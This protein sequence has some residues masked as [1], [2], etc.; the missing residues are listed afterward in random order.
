MHLVEFLRAARRRAVP[1]LALLAVSCCGL[2][3]AE[4]ARWSA[5]QP[6]KGSGMA[7]ASSPDSTWRLAPAGPL[8]SAELEP[9][10]D[11]FKRASF[12]VRLDRPAPGPVWLTVG[13][14]DRGYGVI[15]PALG[16]EG[17]GVGQADAHGAVLLN[18]GKL[19]HAVFRLAGGA[20][21]EFKLFGLPHLHSLT[22]SDAAPPLEPLP[23]VPPAF[24]L[25]RPLDLVITAGADAPTVEGLPAALAHLRS[26]LPLMKA[27]GFTGIESYVKWNFVERS[28]GVFDW[29]YYDAIVAEVER[30]GMRWFP[31]L[32]VGSAYALPDWFFESGENA[33][34]VCLEHNQ[35]IEIPTIF[36]GTQDRY[37]RRFL[38]EFGKHYA[39]R[40][41]LQGIRLGPSGNYGEAQYPATGAW[42]YKGRP[43]HT[44]IGW[45][46]ADP[47]AQANFRAWL[48][49]RYPGAEQLNA[50]WGTRYGAFSEVRT[51]LPVAAH[52][53]RMRLDF[54]TWYLDAMSEWCEQWAVWARE[55]MPKT[56][57]YQS[58]G[59]WG[60]VE[61]GTDY[62][63]Q[64]RAMARLAG[65]IRMTNENDSYLNNFGNTRLAA[66]AARFYGAKWGTEPAGFSSMRGVVAR[67]YNA[68]A[69]DAEHLFYYDGN[70]TG[71][72]QAIGAW[73]RFAPLLDG[74]GRPRESLAVLFPDTANKL[75]DDTLRYLRASALLQRVQALRAVA[76]F[77]L[78]SEQM[79]LDGALGRYQ[80][81]VIPWGNV[82]ENAV[83][84][85][86]GAWVE[87]G[88]A[89]FFPD[90]ELTREGPLQTVE[91]DASVYRRWQAGATGKG[92]VLLFTGQSEPFSAFV[93][94]VRRELRRFAP[95]RADVKA[96]L[97]IE[98]PEDTYWTLMEDGRRVLLNYGDAPAVVTP[99]GGASL[100]LAP[101]TIRVL[102]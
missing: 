11:Y 72:D 32:I 44:H 56:P 77:D 12:A 67:I 86:I 40:P 3:A 21:G 69:N 43:L 80:A 99:P 55:A 92:K 29:S 51:F 60:A 48:A 53:A 84:D 14:L 19:R 52:T 6:L 70:L 81:L 34:F 95:L 91:G 9:V 75:R 13:F 101:Y 98:K 82:H 65:G 62:A 24:T 47:H 28:P 85:K 68:L 78:V 7:L 46:A 90:R 1:A 79:V 97:A 31:L 18:T 35:A 45:W 83:L 73:L 20:P 23:Q 63:A 33:P 49:R 94:Y 87:A 54:A 100:T 38:S 58:S 36:A 2:A 71:T 22:L 39:A 57:I 66:A 4:L 76:D 42:G 5:R 41:V 89:V 27:L 8:A 61:I 74:R 102:P 59:G 37:V 50:A 17:R 25:R 16:A 93:A 30:H 26:M 96:A 64:A 10:R 88:G 15:S